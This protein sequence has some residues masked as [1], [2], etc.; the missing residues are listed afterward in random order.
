MIA[1]LLTRLPALTGVAGTASAGVGVVSVK[2]SKSVRPTALR[3]ALQKKPSM[4]ISTAVRGRGPAAPAIGTLVA[5]LWR[6]SARLQEGWPYDNLLNLSKRVAHAIPARKSARARHGAISASVGSRFI[7]KKGR[8]CE[9]GPQ[10]RTARPWRAR[11]TC[12]W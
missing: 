10:V 2:G 6:A 11:H 4:S 7:W 9:H 5:P 8:R 12:R 1:A 3:H